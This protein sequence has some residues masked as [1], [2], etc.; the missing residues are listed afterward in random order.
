MKRWTKY[1]MLAVLM[2]ILSGGCGKTAKKV[3]MSLPEEGDGTITATMDYDFKEGMV[4]SPLTGELVDEKIANNRV[5]SCMINNIDVAM[6]QSGL[7][8]ADIMYECVVEGGITRLM[9]I[10]QDYKDIPKLGPVRSARHYYVD[11]SNEYD[12]IYAHFGQTKYAVSEMEALHTNELSGLSAL[13][14]VVYYRDNS[15]VAPHNAYTDGKKIVKGIK[16]AKFEKKNTMTEPRFTFN[17]EQ[18]ELTA[19]DAKNAPVVKLTFNAYSHPYFEYHKK[20]GLYYRFQYGTKHIDDQTGKQ[21]AYENII[22]QFAGYSNIDKKG[23]QDL[24]LVSS[25][26]G[27]YITE[28]KRVPITWEKNSKSEFTNFYT[29]DGNALKV[30]PGKTWITVF[31]DNNK[32]GVS[33]KE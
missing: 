17:M 4:I 8:Y 19:E 15:R 14:G 7:S 32:K 30:N 20:D 10:F 29:A 31:P 18:E 24:A 25:G 9:G 5:V 27:Y 22:I 11:Y 33:F 28:G 16:K 6:P 23:Y 1:M 21:L 26:D 3:D 12:A 13:G 2:V